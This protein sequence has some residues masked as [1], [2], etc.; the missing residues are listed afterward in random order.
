MLSS[1]QRAVSIN[2]LRSAKRPAPRYVSAPTRWS[3]AATATECAL[4]QLA[5]YIGKLKS[6]I[7]GDLVS[8]FSKRGDLVVDPFSGPG[9]IPLEALLLGRRVFASAISSYAATL[10][11][12]KIAAPAS[13]DAVIREA[14]DVIGR[15]AGVSAK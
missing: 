15:L 4:H 2:V 8:S 10:T 9:T 14:Q 13:E 1:H 11:R 7:A 6:T 12:A 5:P 3:V